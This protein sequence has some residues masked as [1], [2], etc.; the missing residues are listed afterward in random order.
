[1]A[2]SAS[3]AGMSPDQGIDMGILIYELQSKMLDSTLEDRDKSF[4]AKGF[5]RL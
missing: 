4:M 5:L 1:M 3:S 2:A